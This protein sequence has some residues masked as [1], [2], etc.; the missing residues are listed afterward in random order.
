[1]E[2]VLEL[3]INCKV[4]PQTPVEDWPKIIIQAHNRGYLYINLDD[5][6]VKAAVMAYRIPFY[7][8]KFAI[9]IPNKDYGN[10]LYVAW[11]CSVSDHMLTLLRMLKGYLSMFP[12]VDE[13]YY[14]HRGNDS[15]LRS[16]KVNNRER[17]YN[18]TKIPVTT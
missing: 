3:V 5:E 18:E 11:A 1:M 16:F 4:C 8:E 2:D 9:H 7:D 17:F 13:V 14:H 10:K 12:L 15:D 6:Q